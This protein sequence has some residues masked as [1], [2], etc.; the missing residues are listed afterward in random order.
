MQSILLFLKALPDVVALLKEGLSE[1]R[2]FK[3]DIREW[4]A[5]REIKELEDYKRE[6]NEIVARIENAESKEE[7]KKLAKELSNRSSR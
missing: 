6:V 3:Q 4:K 2:E 1:F 5:N 7:R